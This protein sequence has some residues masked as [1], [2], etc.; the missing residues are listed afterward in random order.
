VIHSGAFHLGGCASSQMKLTLDQVADAFLAW[1]RARQRLKNVE[2]SLEDAKL[3]RGPDPQLVVYL[4]VEVE[5]QRATVERL[6]VRAAELQAE[7][8]N[9]SDPQ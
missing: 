8:A 9:L 2:A 1:G 6:L 4:E 3:R 7:F 5:K